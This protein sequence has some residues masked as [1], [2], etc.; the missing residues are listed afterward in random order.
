MG[1]AVAGRSDD[2][3]VICDRLDEMTR[4]AD[5]LAGAFGQ[6]VLA[7]E[8]RR[9]GYALRRRIDIW[10]QV[11]VSDIPGPTKGSLEQLSL[12]MANVDAV[13]AG[14]T[15]Q[16]AWRDY[17]LLDALGETPL[18]SEP[19]DD[20]HRQLLARRILARVADTSW[21]DSQRAFLKSQ[22]FDLLG[23]ELRRMAAGPV[24]STR[25]L[26][27]LERYEQTR[28]PS[29]ARRL[30]DECLW[31]A[32][33][34]D[35]QREA[36]YRQITTHYRNANMR[37]VLTEDLLNRLMPERP[38]EYQLVRD[39]VLGNP[40]RGESLTETDVAVRLIPDPNRLLL[41]LQIS[42]EVAALTSSTS[43]P[44]TFRNASQSKYVVRK[45]MQLTMDGVHLWPA[46]VQKVSNVTRLRALQ[47]DLDGIPLIG[48]L[49]QEVAR[50]QHEMKQADVRREIE[51]KVAVRAKR[52][53]DE[54][55]DARLGN[56]SKRL[57][58]RALE[59][60]RKMGLDPALIDAQTTE[61]RLTM[62]LRLASRRQLGAHT[63]RPMAPSDSLAS[64]Q[65]HETAINNLVERLQ[66]NGKTFTVG[67]LRERIA[68]RLG[69]PEMKENRTQHDDDVKITFAEKD[70]VRVV[71]DDGRIA[72]NLSIARLSKYP[73]SWRDFQVRVY[74]R[75]EV[76]GLSALLTR[77]GVVQLTGRRVRT[78]SQ[79]ALRGIFSCIFTK[80]RP[81]QIMP[82][83]I[84]NHPKTADLALTQLAVE[85]GWIAVAL[86]PKRPPVGMAVRR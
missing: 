63:P 17:L 72:V 76:D 56:V 9:A 47:T 38:P 24:D 32:L 36:L 86:G 5:R 77:D 51:Q 71:C 31:I 85:D 74:Y 34:R 45:P 35:E 16:R 11:L 2:V 4:E 3:P 64:F 44:A 54:E 15:Q 27:C 14:A 83:R 57:K 37:V 25:M 79:V 21:D 23:V 73:R 28:L 60:I 33:L 52:R 26:E 69:R 20:A 62:R 39:T 82:E 68:D 12:A 84:L 59:P 19:T 41:S 46:E 53:I 43:G 48:S 65:V 1:K 22:P 18:A 49:V 50:T 29:D 8:L 6:R 40:V 58:Q 80:N 30:A 67:Q 55:T 42:G 13:M 10:R 61:R 66:L 78:A 70:A 7:S 81:K 75:T